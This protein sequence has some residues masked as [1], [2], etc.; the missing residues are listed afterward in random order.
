MKREV[1]AGVGFLKRLV[2]ARGK[3]D[4]AKA[5]LFAEKLQQLLC[6]KFDGHWYPECPTK[7]QAFRCIRINE[8]LPNDDMLLKA[9][10]ESE[11]TPSDLCLPPEITVWIDP[12]EVCVRSR[13]NGFPFSIACFKDK[14]DDE[15]GQEDSSIDS[16]N[17]D[18][19]DYHSATSSDC[20]STVC[21]DTE[22]EAK[23]GETEGEQENKALV[24]EQPV[25]D[26][27][28]E[29]TMVPRIRKR[30]GGRARK[31]KH[32]RNGVQANLHYYF[33][34]VPVWPHCKNGAPVFLT[35]VAAPPPTP[36]PPHQMYMH[37][38]IPQPPPH[39]IIPRTTLQPC[40]YEPL[41]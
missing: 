34:P 19:S 35:T 15:K 3:I 28:V 24:K 6:A 40:G 39:F 2:V 10:E 36:L 32:G 16:T 11:L 31:T 1:K 7:G 13:E 9:C 22:E 33:P 12:M 8:G 4:E 5:Q 41:N 14:E 21:S 26:N 27:N 30:H 23:D 37:Y 17:H 20:G 29:I 18:T 25:Q 38:M